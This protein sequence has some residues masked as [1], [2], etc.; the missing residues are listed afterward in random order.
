MSAG[1]TAGAAAAA[2][3]LANASA[4]FGPCLRVEPAEFL[5]LLKQIDAPLVVACESSGWFTGVRYRY[6]TSYKGLTFYAKSPTPLDLPGG[7]ELVTVAKMNVP[8]L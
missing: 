6:L 2:A 8:Y 7:A 1:A 3:Q 5:R 4:S